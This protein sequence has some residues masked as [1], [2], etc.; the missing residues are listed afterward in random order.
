MFVI[1]HIKT[2]ENGKK[3]SQPEAAFLLALNWCIMFLG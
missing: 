2:N 1:P 3:L